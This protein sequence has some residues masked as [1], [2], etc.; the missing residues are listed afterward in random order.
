VPLARDRGLIVPSAEGV[1]FP[2]YDS[3]AERPRAVKCVVTRAALAQLAGRAL[4]IHELEGVFTRHRVL[5]ESA[6]SRLHKHSKAIHYL[7]TVAPED[8]AAT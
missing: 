6:A 7:L 3:T 1:Y 2:M 8:L 4:A 5:V